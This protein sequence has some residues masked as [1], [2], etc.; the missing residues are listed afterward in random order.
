M[1][2]GEMINWAALVQDGPIAGV[3]GGQ[4]LV[5]MGFASG[6]DTGS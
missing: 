3:T 1:V 2:L 5:V 4:S 6:R